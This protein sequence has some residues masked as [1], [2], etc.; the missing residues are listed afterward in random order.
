MNFLENLGD[1]NKF[2]FNLFSLIPVFTIILQKMEVMNRL[3]SSNYDYEKEILANRT[4]IEKLKIQIE[5]CKQVLQ[6]QV[7][8][9][10]SKN[11]CETKN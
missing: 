1:Y 2:E 5:L 10:N 11:Y 4:E 8:R 3:D 9:T 7:N 6:R